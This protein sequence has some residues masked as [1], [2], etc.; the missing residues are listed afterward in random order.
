MVF[1]SGAE[2]EIGW[3]PLLIRQAGNANLQP[4]NAGYLMAADFI[5]KLEIPERLDRSMGDVHPEGNPHLVTDPRNMLTAAKIFAERIKQLDS[6]HAGDYDATYAAFQSRFSA[7]IAGWE[8][9]AAKLRGLVI[10][11]QHRHWSYL[12]QWLGLR[13]VATLEQKPGVSPTS[14]HMAS[15]LETVKAQPINA[16]LL[17]PFEDTKGA[18]WLAEKTGV[19]IITLPYTVVVGAGNRPL[20]PLRGDH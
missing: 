4:G 20:Q 7:A 8:A 5:E 3:L 9:K 14:S 12:A 11:T 17:A 2:L 1:C 15:L 18:E 19:P 13:V 16:I 6:V 10:V